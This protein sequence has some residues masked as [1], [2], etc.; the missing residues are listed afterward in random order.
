MTL[1]L[2]KLTEWRSVKP[3][4]NGLQM[5]NVTDAERQDILSQ[6]VL[7]RI[8]NVKISGHPKVDSKEN[9]EEGLIRE[10]KEKEKGKHAELDLWTQ[11]TRRTN[12]K[13]I[14]P[15]KKK[16]TKTTKMMNVFASSNN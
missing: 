5:P 6:I 10:T 15:K 3:L 11:M 16:M 13:M 4:L 9:H 14:P 12:Q 2:C 1:T 7:T 8:R